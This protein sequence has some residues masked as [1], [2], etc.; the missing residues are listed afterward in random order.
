MKNQLFFGPI[1]KPHILDNNSYP[2]KSEF[3]D[4]KNK[5]TNKQ[6]PT[7]DKMITFLS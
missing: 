1:R 6:H 4:D 7:S 5:T 2:P 3:D